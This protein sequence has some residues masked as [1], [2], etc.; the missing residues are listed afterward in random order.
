[1]INNGLLE[2]MVKFDRSSV[3]SLLVLEELDEVSFSGKLSDGNTFE[4]TVE[5]AYL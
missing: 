5:L 2:L 3:I 4:G 1:M